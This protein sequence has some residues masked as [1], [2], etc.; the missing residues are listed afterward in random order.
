M[1][2]TKSESKATASDLVE[3]NRP[4]QPFGACL[5]AFYSRA[6]EAVLGGAAGTG[7]SLACLNKIFLLCQR[8]PGIRCLIVRK[9]RESLTESALVTWENKVLPEGSPLKEGAERS[10]RSKYVFPNGSEVIVAGLRQSHKDATQKIMSTEFDI[11]YV[12]E[13]IELNED[14]WERLTSRLRN[15]KMPYQ[16]LI[17]DTNP[18]S[19]AHW[20]KKRCDRGQTQYL[21]SKHEDNPTL[22]D[23]VTKK[24]TEWGKTYIARLD[25]LTGPRKLRLRHG[26]WVQA[27]GIVYEGW[28]AT[29]HIID[30]FD[31]PRDWRRV[32]GI[33]FGYTNSFVAQWWALDHDDR[34]YLYREWVRSKMMVEHHAARIKGMIGDEPKPYL[35]VC[36]HD[37]E[38]RATLE[39]HLGL[40]TVAAK[41]S[42]QI[43]IQE[44]AS[45]L[46]V[47]G[48]GKP[49]LFVL[50][51]AL[52]DR[53]PLLDEAKK[54]IGL[55]EEIDG[56][57]WQDDNG[58]TA[59]EEPVKLND[60]SVDTCRYVCMALQTD[61]PWIDPGKIVLPKPKNNWLPGKTNSG[62]KMFGIG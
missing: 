40:R 9:T 17:A 6:S 16:Q 48:D 47:V 36:D 2:S 37:A 22:F 25:A 57:I 39:Y 56:Y 52:V 29:K 13:A 14:E 30:H 50:R 55:S 23:P 1:E 26:K 33:D 32:L 54:P 42:V 27:E 18:S 43:G 4:Y 5:D 62:K 21:D 58:K 49:R 38:D 34:I 61:T 45:R 44:V 60:H 59:K 46:Q 24:I 20:L 41:K 15:G 3:A 12:Q 7:K 28:D 8:Y 19:P 35:I 53:D 31:I 51:G 11:I 10:N